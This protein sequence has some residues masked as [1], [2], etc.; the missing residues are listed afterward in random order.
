MSLRRNHSAEAVL[1]PCESWS[2]LMAQRFTR[3]WIA[4]GQATSLSRLPDSAGRHA[5]PEGRRSMT[6]GDGAQSASQ[7]PHPLL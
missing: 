1:P 7:S 6:V 3:E 5:G 4:A 2:S